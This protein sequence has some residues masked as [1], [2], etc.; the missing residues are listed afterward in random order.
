[1]QRYSFLFGAFFLF[2]CEN[3]NSDEGML[4]RMPIAQNHAEKEEP[5]AVALSDT[6]GERLKS[7]GLVEVRD[8]NPRIRVDL[9]YASQ[10]NFMKQNVYGNLSGAYL[11]VDVAEMLGRAQESLTQIDTS[12]FLLVYDAVRPV[13]VQRVMWELLD[14]IPI[15]NR[16]KFVSNPKNGSLHNFGAAVDLTICDANGVPLDMGAE[17]DDPAEI[18]YPSL[19]YKFLQSGQLTSDQIANRK[20]LRQ[21]MRKAGFSVLPTEWWHFN[22][23]SREQARSRYTL[24]K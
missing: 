6:L 12:L 14:S 20:L 1:M 13:W 7:L 24:V 2:G 10:D 16:T 3:S 15:H 23:M 8:L 4:R 21:V 19:E 18:A 5:E 17:Y 11:Q 9:K 22:A